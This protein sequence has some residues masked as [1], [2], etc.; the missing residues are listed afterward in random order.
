MIIS[1]D[2]GPN[3]QAA[4]FK[5][6]KGRRS[7]TVISSHHAPNLQDA[8][9]QKNLLGWQLFFEGWILQ[10]WAGMQQ[11]YYNMIKSCWSE[12]RWAI[13]SSILPTAMGGIK[14]AQRTSP[15]NRPK[16][17]RPPQAFWSSQWHQF[18]Q[19]YAMAT[20]CIKIW[21]PGQH[22]P[23]SNGNGIN[24]NWERCIISTM[25]K[26]NDLYMNHSGQGYTIAL[27]RQNL[28][29]KATSSVHFRHIQRTFI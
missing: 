6:L 17:P 22:H 25:M 18:L 29:L 8:A 3:I 4:V 26:T 16:I 2:T 23:C 24:I 14:D 28:S 27:V 10:D 12:K 9:Q 11:P 21:A 7:S 19:L 13:L 15:L 1:V 20:S 5:H